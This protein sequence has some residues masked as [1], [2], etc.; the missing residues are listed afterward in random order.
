MELVRTTVDDAPNALLAEEVDD[1]VGTERY[2]RTADCE[3]Y[4][5]GHHNR[6]LTATSGN[7]TLRMP[8]LKALWF[9]TAIV[10]RHKKQETRVGAMI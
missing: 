8:K 1:L 5:V 6:A 4:R 3:A 9:A 7:V 2:G 10:D